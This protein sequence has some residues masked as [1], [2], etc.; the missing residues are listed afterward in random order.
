MQIENKLNY[1]LLNLW[2]NVSDQVP[3]NGTEIIALHT[4]G[5]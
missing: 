2:F 3:W 4:W 5:K 1:I